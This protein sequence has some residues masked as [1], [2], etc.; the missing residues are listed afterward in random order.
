MHHSHRLCLDNFFVPLYIMFPNQPPPTYPSIFII[1]FLFR[2]PSSFIISSLFSFFFQTSPGASLD[3]RGRRRPSTRRSAQLDRHERTRT[4]ADRSLQ[5]VPERRQHPRRGRPVQR[6][7]THRRVAR[8]RGCFHRARGAHGR[9]QSQRQPYVI[10]RYCFVVVIIIIIIIIII[11]TLL[12]I[13][14][15]LF[16]LLLLLSLKLFRLPLYRSYC[17]N[18]VSSFLLVPL[19]YRLTADLPSNLVS[20]F[21]VLFVLFGI[22]YLLIENLIVVRSCGGGH[23]RRARRSRCGGEAP[24]VQRSREEQ[25]RS[26]RIRQPFWQRYLSFHRT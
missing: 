16:L 18:S 15:L 7:R 26:L 13:T 23:D 17:I 25:V 10:K 1:Y 9:L 8:I 14:F 24:R 12:L 22:F 11:I 21:F 2:K 5:P 19:L 6:G 3:R 4:R 20:N